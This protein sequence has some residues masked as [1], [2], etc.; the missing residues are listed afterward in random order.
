MIEESG[1]VVAIDGNEI[2]VETV[3]QS[4]CGSCTAKSGCGQGLM[5][6]FTDGKRN[7]IR[8]TSDQPVH[9]GDQVVM[10]I[11]EH[12]LV[13]SAL[14][15]YGFPLILF[16]LFAGLADSVFGLSELWVILVGFAGLLSGFFLVRLT[17]GVGGKFASF[18]PI[19]LKVLP[20]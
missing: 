3:R 2:W 13:K 7:H 4:A 16:V 6:K 1:R 8:L 12:T 20:G 5:A 14:L 10:G 19:I 15:V 17:T 9:L 11:P 18:K